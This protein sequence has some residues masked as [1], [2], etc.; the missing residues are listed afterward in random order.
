ME[1]LLIDRFKVIA[2]W[3]EMLERFSIGYVFEHPYGRTYLTAESKYDPADFPHLFKKLNWWEERKLEDMPMYVRWLETELKDTIEKIYGYDN[4]RQMP[5]FNIPSQVN[6]I[7]AD[8]FI[9]STEEEYNNYINSKLEN[10]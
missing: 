3:P 7:K 2:D 1:D 4:S 10:K 9:P 8:Y 6:T 5:A